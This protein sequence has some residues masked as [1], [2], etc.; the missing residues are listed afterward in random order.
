MLTGYISSFKTFNDILRVQRLDKAAA[1]KQFSRKHTC[2]ASVKWSDKNL[3]RL[4]ELSK[5]KRQ[6]I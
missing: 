1:P 5:G 6:Y 2:L 4:Y 3:F